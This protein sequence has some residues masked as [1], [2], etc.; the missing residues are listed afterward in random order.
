MP[1][2][3]QDVLRSSLGP[4]YRIEREL[5]GGGMSRVF[6][7]TDIGLDRAVVV[8][9]L[10]SEQT[11]GVSPDRFRREIQ[12]TAKLQHPHI[13]PL[14]SAGTADGVLYYVMPYLGG[15][16]LRARLVREGPLAVDV[17]VRILRGVL[18]ALA[19]AHAHGVVHRDIK[20]ENILLEAGHAVVADFG[21]AKALRE[22]GSVTSIGLALG[23]PAYMAPEQAAGD[24]TLDHRSDLYALGVMAFEMLTGTAP[25]T[26][27][28]QQVI[29]AHIT[30]AAPSVRDRRSD[31]PM[32]LAHVVMRALEKNPADR[33]SSASEM[34]ASV[35]SAV[36][37]P[38]PRSD[39]RE[40]VI[41]PRRSR[42]L[43]RVVPA[44]VV[45]L[46][47]LAAWRVTRPP[48]IPSAQSM[49]IAPFAVA[50]GDTALVRLGQN[51]VTTIGANLDGLGEIRMA[52]GVAVL[53]HAREMGPM[54]SAAAAI[55]I[56]RS[57][58]A[59]SVVH[60]TLVPT[61]DGVRANAALYDVAAPETPVARLSA[62]GPRD[63]L[64]VLTDSLTFQLLRAVWSRGSPPSP[65]VG[66]ISTRSPLALREFLEGE[67]LFARS[68]PLEAAEAYK[69]AVAAD[70]TFWFAHY[71]YRLAR[72]WMSETVDPAITGRLAKH[73]RELPPRE[74]DLVLAYDSSTS[75][76]DRL[77]RHRRLTELYPDYAGA[78]VAFA[79]YLLHHAPR[80][81]HDVREAIEPWEEAVR[82][83]PG[84]LEAAAT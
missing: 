46:G 37:L 42:M 1:A 32:S 28:P 73:L 8:K 10:S 83:M 11:T 52:D 35:E 65:N 68:G 75:L 44:V 29:A 9:V 40:A 48:V 27:S 57:L 69:R 74:R 80:A 38:T 2:D 84:D 36:S 25:F 79:D 14:L 19:F 16:S 26:G 72:A 53:S 34:L 51:L 22:S 59:R 78:W 64:T 56:A 62:T 61:T 81:G 70:T 71:R 20:P 30:A 77:Q 76:T 15:E 60:G 41:R 7:A 63:G 66:S 5:G 43:T 55:S 58:G 6:L 54:V 82:L 31:V 47:G 3:L 49:A 12:V 67:R 13:V 4:G 23:T 21:V 45:V 17:T 24:P 39:E 33:P 50:S 18:D